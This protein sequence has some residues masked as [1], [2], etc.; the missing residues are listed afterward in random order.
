MRL[1]K[2]FENPKI[3]SYVAHH[4]G[5]MLDIKQELI[6]A[7]KVIEINPFQEALILKS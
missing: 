3:S 4:F 7:G 2:I 1:F 5:W 6:E